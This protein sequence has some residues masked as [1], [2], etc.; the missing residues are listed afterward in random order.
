MKNSGA[1]MDETI[2]LNKFFDTIRLC[3]L[4]LR[5]PCTYIE[6]AMEKYAIDLDDVL[7]FIQFFIR[8]CSSNEAIYAIADHSETKEIC[9][10]SGSGFPTEFDLVVFMEGL[11]VYLSKQKREMVIFKNSLLI[12]A[13]FKNQFIA[14]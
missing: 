14:K 11:T 9:S 12:N 7:P 2:K 13:H 6:R 3:T 10:G 5:G 1:R 4:R 8:Q